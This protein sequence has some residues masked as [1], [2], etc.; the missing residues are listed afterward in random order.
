[1]QQMKRSSL[2]DLSC[3]QWCGWGLQ[4]TEHPSPTVATKSY[5]K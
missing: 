5:N 2:Y 4:P 3:I 1:M